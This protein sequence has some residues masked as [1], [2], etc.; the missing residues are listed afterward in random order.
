MADY[1]LDGNHEYESC[2][3]FVKGF[4]DDEMQFN[5]RKVNRSMQRKCVESHIW[6]VAYRAKHGA[7]EA[8]KATTELLDEVE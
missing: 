1:I 6:Y 7:K 3:D 4:F 5:S 8:K 2:I